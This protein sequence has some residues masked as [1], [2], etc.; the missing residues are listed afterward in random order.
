MSQ[1]NLQIINV[2]MATANNEYSIVI[3]SG[4]MNVQMK[5]ADATHTVMVYQTSV[6]NGGSPANFWTIDAAQISP[7]G[8]TKQDAQTIYLMSGTASVSLQVSYYLDQ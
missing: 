6:G 5:L 2:S 7:F 4:A 1:R 3:P 8:P